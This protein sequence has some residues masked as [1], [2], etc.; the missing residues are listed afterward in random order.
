MYICPTSCRLSLALYLVHVFTFASLW[1]VICATLSGCGSGPLVDAV[2]WSGKG[3]D[4]VIVDEAC[5]VSTRRLS[6]TA[7]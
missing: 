2:S 3:F 6:R 5:Q 7:A 1:Q 4:T